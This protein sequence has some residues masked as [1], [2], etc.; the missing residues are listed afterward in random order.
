MSKQP[1]YIIVNG[2]RKRNPARLAVDVLNFLKKQEEGVTM[3]RI[4]FA[5][6]AGGEAI[7]LALEG[8]S[9]EGLIESVQSAAVTTNRKGRT[10]I[11]WYAAGRV[12]RKPAHSFGAAETL[13]AFQLAARAYLEVR[14]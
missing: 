5:L 6:R 9:A 13:Q 7:K 14:A 12:A 8:L 10:D 1:Q 4:I 11:Y 2:L 3:R